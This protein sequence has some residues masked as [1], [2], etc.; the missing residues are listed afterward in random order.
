MA[1]QYTTGATHA[2]AFPSKIDLGHILNLTIILLKNSN[3]FIIL[4]MI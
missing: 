2:V 4:Y 1:T 3:Y